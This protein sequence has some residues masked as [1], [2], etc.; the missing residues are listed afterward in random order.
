MVR[1]LLSCFCA[2]AGCRLIS[3]TADT[4]LGSQVVDIYH[5]AMGIWTTAQLSVGRTQLAAT[6]VGGMAIFAGGITG[7]LW[8]VYVEVVVRQ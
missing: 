3:V 5:S 4:Q 8:R 7:V 2:A 1:L 6:S